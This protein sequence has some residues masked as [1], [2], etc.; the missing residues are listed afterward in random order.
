LIDEARGYDF[1]FQS[2]GQIMPV[3]GMY[4]VTTP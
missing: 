3:D 1:G 4:R 2:P